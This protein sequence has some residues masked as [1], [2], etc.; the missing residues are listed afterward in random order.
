MVTSV[1]NWL[2]EKGYLTENHCPIMRPG[3]RTQ[4]VLVATPYHANGAPM[5]VVK[6]VGPL[7]METDYT[8]RD[9]TR[10]AKAIIERV[11][12]APSRF[13]LRFP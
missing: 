11:G 4:Y 10:N 12:Q 3:G 9:L 5:R 7:Y 6:T 8:A 1:A 2:H 13:K